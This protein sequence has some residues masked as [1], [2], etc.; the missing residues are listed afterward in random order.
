[1]EDKVLSITIPCY[2]EHAV[3]PST[4]PLFK[5]EIDLLKQKNKISEQSKILFV[6]DG[7][8]DNTWEI[9]SELSEQDPV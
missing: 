3:L 8:S 1:M 7:S 4:A 5:A 2:N 6:N 9:I